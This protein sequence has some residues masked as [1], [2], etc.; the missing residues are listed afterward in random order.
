MTRFGWHPQYLTFSSSTNNATVIVKIAPK[1]RLDKERETLQRFYRRPHVRQ[2]IDVIEQPPAIVC[3][4]FE[5]DLLRA[6]NFQ[7]LE[8]V[9]LKF[10]ARSILKA[11]KVLHEDGSVHTGTFILFCLH[12]AVRLTQDMVNRYQAR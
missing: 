11:L 2:L 6:S 1:L 3:E 4:Y 9:D 12:P 7:K 10:V 5:D 8:R